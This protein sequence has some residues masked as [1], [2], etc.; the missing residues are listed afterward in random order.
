MYSHFP[1]QL[2]VSKQDFIDCPD[3]KT[4]W[5]LLC[6]RLDYLRVHLLLERLATERGGASKRDLF[7]VAQEMLDL[8]VFL[9]VQRDRSSRRQHHYD[10]MIMSYGMPSIGLLCTQLLK[11]VK[12]PE[13]AEIKLPIS[14]IVQNLSLMISFLE[15]I[16]PTAGSYKLC[17]PLS[18]VIR[19]VIDQLLE[20]ASANVDVQHDQSMPQNGFEENVWPLD[21]MDDL[22]WL[23]SIDWTL[24]QYM[25]FS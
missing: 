8:T 15:W 16:R 25:D 22:D 9:W 13:Q 24:G 7:S 23:N 18:K 19:R 20:P 1:V 12:H 4:M 3:D 6:R 2:Q 5:H 17:Q 21:G 14:E 11:Q 10:Y